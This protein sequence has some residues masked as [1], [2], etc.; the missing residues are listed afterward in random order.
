M[1]AAFASQNAIIVIEMS[2]LLAVV[3]V[4][5]QHMINRVPIEVFRIKNSGI[6]HPAR[7]EI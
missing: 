7:S 6:V 3:P 4:F 5:P 1:I 2:V